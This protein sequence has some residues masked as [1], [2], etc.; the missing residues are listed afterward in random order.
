[1]A[2]VLSIEDQ[3]RAA[4]MGIAHPLNY[5]FAEF[6]I[7]DIPDIQLLPKFRKITQH[8]FHESA[9]RA[10]VLFI[11]LISFEIRKIGFEQ[12]QY[13]HTKTKQVEAHDRR[14]SSHKP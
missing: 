7:I 3:V 10:V 4:L 5:F 14:Q 12:K 9:I 6:W 8:T 13:V 11:F 1:M 2:V